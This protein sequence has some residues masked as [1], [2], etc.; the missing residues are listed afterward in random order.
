[1]KPLPY[2]ASHFIDYNIKVASVVQG[3]YWKEKGIKW[4]VRSFTVSW[5]IVI[6]HPKSVKDLKE[7]KW[8]KFF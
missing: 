4:R 2:R 3:F 7:G 8:L 1:M 5:H 6:Q